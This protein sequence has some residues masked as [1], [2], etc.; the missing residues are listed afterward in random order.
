MD[1]ML[2]FI[3]NPTAG[4]KDGA[5]IKR[6]LP[7]I[8]KRLV[9]RGVP[10]VIHMTKT[11]H[12]ATSLTDRLIKNGATD[13]IVVGGDG[14][15]H[16][17]INGFSEFDRVALGIIPCG[18]GNDYADALKIPSDPVEALD[19]IL[20]GTPQYTDFMQMPTVRGLNII[21]TGVDVDV[22]KRYAKCKKKTKFK[23]TL[24]LIS[25]LLHLKMA[26]FDAEFNGEK[27]SYRSLIACVANGKSY[28]GGIPICPVAEPSDK[29]LDFL[30]VK[31]LRGFKLIGAFLKLKKGRIME[32]PETFHDK[33]EEVKIYPKG[34]YTVNVDGELY[35]DIPF[36]VKIVS[37]TLRVYM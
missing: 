11:P 5:K 18:T 9:E 7:K 23:Y 13:I 29:K 26:E 6:A 14:T 4:G 10:Y 32:F 31:E 28:G 30:A 12:H 2:D 20:D 35:D 1:K 22:L 33:T 16:E 27:K 21:G 17:V 37:D 24:C 25:S 8:E 15:L 34:S 3:V 36:E 19:K